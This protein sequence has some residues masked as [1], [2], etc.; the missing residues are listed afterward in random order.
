[1]SIGQSKPNTA[2]ISWAQ[3]YIVYRDKLGNLTAQLYQQG[4]SPHQITKWCGGGSWT[5]VK[6]S[7]IGDAIDLVK[8]LFPDGVDGSKFLPYSRPLQPCIPTPALS[9][10][11]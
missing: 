2:D 9:D 5:S 8:Q 7:S 3:E 11:E 1:M 6:A 4:M 10:F